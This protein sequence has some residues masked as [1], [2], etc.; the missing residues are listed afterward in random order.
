MNSLIRHALTREGLGICRVLGY[1]AQQDLEDGALAPVLTAHS[2]P[3][4]GYHGGAFAEA[5]KCY[6][7][8]IAFISAERKHAL[9]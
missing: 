8:K 5:F 7:G 1:Q 2:A 9:N 4:S 6:A 3:V